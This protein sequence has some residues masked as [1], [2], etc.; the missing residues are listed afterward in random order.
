MQKE[1]NM[2]KED[3]LARLDHTL[4]KQTATW[5]DVKKLCDEGMSNGVASVCIPPCYVKPA[6]E[7]AGDDLKICTVIGFPNG[8]HTTAIKVAETKDAIANGASEVDMV[9][10]INW[11]KDKRYDD[12]LQEIRKIR[13]ASEGYTLKVII[14]TCL[15]DEDEKVKLCQIVT[16]AEAD[17]IKTSTGFSSGGATFE[18]VALLRKHVGEKVKVKASGGIA[19]VADAEK[20]VELGADR[21]GTSRLIKLLQE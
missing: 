7:Y 1:V 14:E 16:E 4:L 12:V 10:N 15:L 9:V 17:Y 8:S 11:V 3:I 2:K 20:F 18:D 19:S 21:L 6:A 13:A 5:K